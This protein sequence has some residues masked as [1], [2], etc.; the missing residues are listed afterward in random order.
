MLG[1]YLGISEVDTI[2]QV[3]MKEKIKKSIPGERE[4]YSKPN[5]ITG[6]IQLTALLKSAWILSRVLDLLS[7][8]LQ[9]KPSTSVGLKN[10]QGME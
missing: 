2:K 5:Y 9:W 3:E 7:F 10:L 4:K 6:N 1:E 8:R